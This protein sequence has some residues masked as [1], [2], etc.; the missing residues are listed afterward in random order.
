MIRPTE[1]NLRE[2]MRLTQERHCAR[3]QIFPGVRRTCRRES[4]A[5][6]Q[7]VF[8]T[9][10]A[11]ASPNRWYARPWRSTPDHPGAHASLGVIAAHRGDWLAAEA[12]FKDAF[13]F[14]EGSG[15]VHARYAEAVLNSTGRLREALQDLP[16]GIAQDS[17]ALPRRHAVGDRAWHAAGP[18]RR[19]DALH[20][21]CDEPR[22]AATNPG[23]CEKLN[24]E[25]ARRAGRYAEAAEYQAMTLP[26]ATRLAG[27]VEVVRLLH[28]ALADPAER[29]AALA[30]LDTLNSQGA[31][32]RNGLL[33]HADVL[34]ELVHDAG[35]SRSRL[36]GQRTLAAESRR[37]RSAQASLTISDSGCRRCARFAPIRAFR[38]WRDAWD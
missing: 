36:S 25:V 22:L 1:E 10:S 35:R 8:A 23:T 14:D 27:A 2:V 33:R 4:H 6:G 5:S 31:D 34:H 7:W 37:A 32:R 24:S 16:G 12:H 11:R 15:R 26:A 21:H 30:S 28:K 17:D 18:R 13:E 20:R 3:S 19:S 38:N 9:G 29:R